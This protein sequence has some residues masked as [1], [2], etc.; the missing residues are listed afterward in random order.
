MSDRIR[1][2]YLPTLDGWRA[3]AVMSVVFYHLTYHVAMPRSLQILFNG[4]G[5]KG[6]ELFFGISGLLI[7]SRLLEEYRDRHGVSLRQFYIR[8]AFRILPPSLMYL[9][10]IALLGLTGAIV[11]SRSGIIAAL[12]FSRNYFGGSWYEGHYWSLAVEEHFYLFWPGIFVLFGPKRARWIAGG[13]ILAVTLWR[14][15]LWLP[16]GNVRGLPW[17]F[18]RTEMRMDA[19]LCGA[20]LA[21]LVDQYADSFRVRLRPAIALPILGIL[22]LLLIGVPGP[23]NSLARLGQAIIIPLALVSTVLHP[24][25]LVSTLL[26]VRW[27]RWIGRLSYSLYIW[28]EL[29]LGSGMKLWPLKLVACFAAA[30][31]S[32]FLVERPAI[33]LGH[34][35][36][37]PT[38]VGRGDLT[39][40]ATPRK[41]ECQ[42]PSALASSTE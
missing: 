17:F 1:G 31:A 32:Y 4:F 20:L 38:S 6:V 19:L 42:T 5:Q 34:R 39:E 35:L 28:Q 3:I 8:R 14:A 41:T 22:F 29:F 33:L 12:L 30:A 9:A 24:R 13:V 40:C 23:L 26:E 10:S 18:Y 11:V 27:L 7:T 21:L 15:V 2:G 36:A 16:L 25:S 37:P